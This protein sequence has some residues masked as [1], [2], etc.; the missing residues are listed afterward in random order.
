MNGVC[1]IPR[2]PRFCVTCVLDRRKQPRGSSEWR[3]A[4]EKRVV[5]HCRIFLRVDSG[6]E[7]AVRWR[8]GALDRHSHTLPGALAWPFS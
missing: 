8:S 6:R 3:L 5:R 4:V 1:D 7:R 2:I